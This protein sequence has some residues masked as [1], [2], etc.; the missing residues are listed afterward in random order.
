MLKRLLTGLI[1]LVISVTVRAQLPQSVNKYISISFSHRRLSEAFNDLQQHTGISFAYDPNIIPSDVRITQT[2]QNVPLETILSDLLKNTQ[3]GYLF[4][5]NQIVITKRKLQN[6]TLDGYVTESQSGEPL[7]GASILVPALRISTLTN[8]YGFFSLTVPSGYYDLEISHLEYAAKKIAVDVK[9]SQ[10]LSFSLNYR[11]NNLAEVKVESA[12]KSSDQLMLQGVKNFTNEQ[13]KEVAYYAGEVDVIKALQMQHGVKAMTEGSSALFVRGG[14]VD[15]NLIMLDEA[16]IYNPSHLFGLVSVFNPDAIKNIQLYK[17]FMPASF[18]G[19]L[20]SALD[21]RMADG[22]NQYYHVKGGVSLMSVRAA[23]EGPIVKNKGSFLVTFRRSLIDLV[24]KDYRLLNPNSTYLDVNAKGNY[25]INKNNKLLY[26]FYAGE[27]K[28]FSENS[29][30]NK[31]GNRTSTVRW[32]HVFSSRLFFNLSAI[33]SN[34]KNSLDLNS[35]TVT[36]KKI[37]RTGIEDKTL[38]TDFTYFINP[39][40]EVKFGTIITRHVFVPGRIENSVFQE[41]NIPANRSWEYALY[42]SHKYNLNDKVIFNYGLRASAFRNAEEVFGV[43]DK[44]EELLTVDEKSVWWGLEPRANINFNLSAKHAL[45]ASYN[46]NYQYLQLIQN[47]ELAFSSLETWMPASKVTKPQNSYQFSSAYNYHSNG[48]WITLGSFYK[49][50]F[51]QV[52]LA[53]HTQ[54]IQNSSIRSYL[55]YGKSEAYGA[56]VGI[57]HRTDKLKMDAG[58]S[59]TRTIKRISGINNDNWFRANYDIPHEFKTSISYR[60]LK[61]L[62]LNGFFICASGRPSTLPVG[63]FV[64]DGIQVPIYEQRNNSRFPVFH[65]LDL[66]A[67]Y[68]IKQKNKTENGW[69]HS[70]TAGIYNVYNKRNPLYYRVSQPTENSNLGIVN[71]STR[72]LPW[73]AYSFRL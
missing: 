23:A 33:Y 43:Y 39:F 69:R 36:E 6:F 14:N 26:S 19:R 73:L 58:Y 45:Q 8:Q 1:L 27:D 18:G 20:S 49:K 7:I 16:M 17:D 71:S 57:S 61:K 37:W 22:N 28:L 47:N 30:T 31:W 9:A 63:Y 12:V 65:R 32:N 62:S 10:R 24:N 3:L 2:Y 48:L 59:W 68:T 56:E 70:I 42:A 60:A 4:V 13:L 21:A 35:D 40:N 64:H 55:R 72:I 41:P 46:R 5:A 51:N 52:E 50:M 67:Q 38:K 54:V 15:Q 34:Y 25:Q 29:F 44:N 66:S 11:Q 53:E